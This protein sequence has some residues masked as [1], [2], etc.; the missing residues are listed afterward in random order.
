M[1]FHGGMTLG[2]AKLHW[3]MMEG[4]KNS[5]YWCVSSKMSLEGTYSCT[6]NENVIQRQLI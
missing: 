4:N 2:R 6:L 3:E 5:F 1:L